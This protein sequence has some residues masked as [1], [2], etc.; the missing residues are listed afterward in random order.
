VREENRKA[1]RRPVSQPVLMVGGD[2]TVIGPCIMV[3]VSAGG[4]R[5]KLAAEIALPSKFILRLSKYDGSMQRHCAVAWRS[6]TFAGVRF[7]GE[8]TRA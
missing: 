5:L 6:E 2:G 7:L 3:D 8:V 1:V 4:A